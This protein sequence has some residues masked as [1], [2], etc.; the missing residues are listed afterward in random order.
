MEMKIEKV[1]CSM[2][3]SIFYIDLITVCNSLPLLVRIF[4]FTLM[5]EVSIES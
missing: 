3:A 2:T 5:Y 1:I 4:G